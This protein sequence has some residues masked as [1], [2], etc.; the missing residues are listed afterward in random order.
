MIKNPSFF[1]INLF[2][3]LLIF[4]AL[5]HMIA[6]GGKGIDFDPDLKFKKSANASDKTAIVIQ[7][8]VPRGNFFL[9]FRATVVMPLL[10]FTPKTRRGALT[11]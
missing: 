10:N 5:G 7:T 3:L 6:N 2:L 1:R 4:L 8:D 9:K 11:C